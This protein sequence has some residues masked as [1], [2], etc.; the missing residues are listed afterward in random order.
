VLVATIPRCFSCSGAKDEARAQVAR[1]PAKIRSLSWHLLDAY[2][3]VI[4]GTIDTPVRLF[5]TS[6]LTPT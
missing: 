2:D 6:V 4:Y 3:G 5:T 1:K